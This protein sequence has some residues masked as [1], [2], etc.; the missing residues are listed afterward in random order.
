MQRIVWKD[1]ALSLVSIRECWKPK[2]ILCVFIV[3]VISTVSWL[4]R[5]D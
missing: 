2:V 5:V 3:G 4:K 1:V